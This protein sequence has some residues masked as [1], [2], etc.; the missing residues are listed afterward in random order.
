LGDRA[1]NIVGMIVVVAAITAI[2]GG[3][4]SSSVIKSMGSAFSGSIHAAL[5][6]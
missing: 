5:G 3:K 1:L 6:H 4:N 2:V